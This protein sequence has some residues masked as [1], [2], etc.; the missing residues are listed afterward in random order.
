MKLVGEGGKITVKY[1]TDT[2]EEVTITREVNDPAFEEPD[3]SIADQS[4]HEAAL[5][6][7]PIFLAK[8]K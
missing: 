1:F 5:I 8:V 7:K 4:G 3:I 6:N 2:G